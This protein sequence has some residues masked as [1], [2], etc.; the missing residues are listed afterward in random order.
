MDALLLFE[1]LAPSNAK[2][3]VDSAKVWV[4]ILA[5]FFAFLFFLFKVVSGYFVANLSV[6][7]ECSRQ[8]DPAD[9]MTDLLTVTLT[10]SKGDLGSVQIHDIQ[11]RNNGSPIKEM[12]SLYKELWRL[13]DERNEKAGKPTEVIWD[14]DY[15][16][17]RSPFITLGPGE[18]TQ[19]ASYCKVRSNQVCEIRAI[20]AGRAVWRPWTPS[21]QWRVSAVCLPRTV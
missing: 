12:E 9:K 14:D 5:Y 10:L 4:E 20:I 1:P 16:K 11:V 2:P 19:L 3:W 6:G 18:Q 21:C 7:I 17:K 13:P 8:S 15:R